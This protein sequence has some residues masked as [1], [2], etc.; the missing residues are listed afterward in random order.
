M[1]FD[2]VANRPDDRLSK[3]GFVRAAGGVA[4]P[5]GVTANVLVRRFGPSEDELSFVLHEL[6]WLFDDRLSGSLGDQFRE[7]IGDSVRALEDD[8]LFLLLVGVG[9]LQSAMDE[10][11]V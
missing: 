10:G 9:D 7:V 4:D 1:R 2:V 3:A 6:E 8:G 11:G 5:V